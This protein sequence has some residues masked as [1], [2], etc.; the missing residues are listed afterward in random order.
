MGIPV[1]ITVFF[2][3]H[4]FSDDAKD[5]DVKPRL[6]FTDIYISRLKMYQVYWVYYY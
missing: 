6:F 1:R 4:N 5:K 3:T 2:F